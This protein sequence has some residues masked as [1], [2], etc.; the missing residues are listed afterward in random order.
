MAI[1]QQ[2]VPTI[3]PHRSK[4]FL[5][6]GVIA[7]IFLVISIAFVALIK[8]R[9]QAESRIAVAT[10]NLAQTMTLTI[11]GQIDTIDVALQA[12]ADDI[13]ENTSSEKFSDREIT[14]IL[15]RQQRRLPLIDH[16]WASN[17]RGDVVYGVGI[18]NPTPNIADRDY[19]LKQLNSKGQ[20][21]FISKPVFGKVNKKWIWVFSRKIENRNREFKGVA[22]AVIFTDRVQEIFDKIKMESGGSIALR[23]DNLGLIARST[24]EKS[25]PIA[26]GDSKISKPFE[27]MLSINMNEGTYSSDGTGPDTFI[28]TYSYRRSEKYGFLVNV[29]LSREHALADWHQ[30][31]TI[32]AGLVLAFAA[33]AI[34]L[35]LTLHRAWNRQKHDM[36]ML[37]ESKE[38]LHAAQRIANLGH[39]TYD[40]TVDH[41]E[42]SDVL[43]S[44]FGIGTDYVRDA[45]H[46]LALI[47]PESREEMAAYLKE[48]MAHGEKFER[49]Y[50]IQR[51]STGEIRWVS[52]LGNIERDANGVAVR[53][54]GTIQ[55]ITERVVAEQAMLERTELLTQSNADLE[56]FA[57][58]AS[59]D[60]QTPLRNIISYS[61]LLTRRYKGKLDSDADDFIDFIIDNSMK[62]SKLITDLLEYSR[63]TSQTRPLELV[64][65]SEA[66]NQALANLRHELEESKA[67]VEIGKLPLVLADTPHLVSLF[68]N[69]IGNAIKYRS[70]DRSPRI[71]ISAIRESAKFWRFAVSD[72]GVGID[73]EYHGKIF[74]IFQ[75]LTPTSDVRG[76]GIG[77]TLCRRI[78]QRFGGTIW[79]ESNPGLGSTFFFRLREGSET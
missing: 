57:Y 52:G 14:E 75:R 5:V 28:R 39:Y 23:D 10:Q 42:S 51:Q 2:T 9:E 78:V 67:E 74:E 21:I 12:V 41:W 60:L 37:I 63:I 69:L 79:V 4:A 38:T 8:M 40:V 32:I 61:Q 36:Q 64:S 76:T 71:S 58:V 43:D 1:Q 70:E 17:E 46:W 3:A 72:N 49:Q 22:F 27:E 34:A 45:E 25:N 50:P 56:Q 53:M 31:A 47:A 77:L 62:M 13:G 19:F 29:G 35:S 73:P 55:D 15:S 54:A 33:A 26:I 65:A 68:Q 11:D 44:L 48:I 18:S 24:Y 16:L 66:A 20:N 6:G 59:H 7:P 30:Q